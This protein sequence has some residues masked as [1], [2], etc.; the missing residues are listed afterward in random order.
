MDDPVRDAEILRVRLDALRV[1]REGAHLLRER[2]EQRAQVWTAGSGRLRERP[3]TG[4]LTI[5]DRP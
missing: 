1:A 3:A 4:Q 2:L 5:W